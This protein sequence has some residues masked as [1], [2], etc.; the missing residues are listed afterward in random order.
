MELGDEGLEL[1]LG[2]SLNGRFG[3]DPGSSKLARSASISDLKNNLV[4]TSDCDGSKV[5]GSGVSRTCSL[6]VENKGDRKRK[7]AVMCDRLDELRRRRRRI[8]NPKDVVPCE[9]ANNSGVSGRNGLIGSPLNRSCNEATNGCLNGHDEIGVAGQWTMSRQQLLSQLS[10]RSESLESESQ[11]I[12]G[13]HSDTSSRSVTSAT[14]P[15]DKEHITPGISQERAKALASGRPR[16]GTTDE[17]SEEGKRMM[18]AVLEN[19]PGVSTK[20]DGPNGKRVE[21]FL[22]RYR[23]GGEVR[24][25]CVCHGNFFTPAGFVKHAGGGDVSH[26][27]KHIVVNTSPTM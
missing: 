19:M 21:G 23:K 25:V 22:Y 26:P 6:P 3:V 2:L 14:P 16:N 1:S 7:D 20:G 9:K 15:R 11:E 17:A 18:K 10:R 5:F 13:V 4:V 24:I 12:K 8:E 27:L